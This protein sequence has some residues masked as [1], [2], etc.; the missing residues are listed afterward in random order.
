MLPCPLSPWLA[1]TP[2]L[3]DDGAEPP[4]AVEHLWSALAGQEATWLNV[5]ATVTH[6]AVVGQPYSGPRDPLLVR[7]AAL[8][9]VG[10]ARHVFD[11]PSQDPAAPPPPPG[12]TAARL[13]LLHS[14]EAGDPELE[15]T[16]KW[17]LQNLCTAYGA[18]GAVGG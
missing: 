6:G 7:A 15:A 9:F 2:L 3:A 1:F 8:A 5:A 11:V 16:A 17:L 12:F 10:A 13:L 14:W 18:P 4:A